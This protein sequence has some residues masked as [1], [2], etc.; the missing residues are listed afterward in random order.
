MNSSIKIIKRGKNEVLTGYQV[1]QDERKGTQ[2]TREMM[3]TVKGWI[4]ELH[5]R[6]QDQEVATSA[7]RKMRVTL[8][9]I[10]LFIFCVATESNCQQLRDA[11]RKVDQAVV[12]IRTEQKGLVPFLQQEMVRSIS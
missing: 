4:A 1:T 7:F 2:N 3:R 6:H 5:R 12:I 8:P 11:F 9:L 10:V